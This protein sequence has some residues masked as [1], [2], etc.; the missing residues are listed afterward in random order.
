MSN[1]N[2]FREEFSLITVFKLIKYKI[3]FFI[4]FTLIFVILVII[5]S[6]IMPN[7][8]LSTASI[9]PP[10]KESGG[11]GL[12][13]FIQS[14]TGGLDIGKISTNEQSKLF[15]KIINSRTVSDYIIE[16]LN[17]S[18]HP[19]FKDFTN[20]KFFKFFSESIS[21]EVDKSGIIY[22]STKISTNF[23]PGKESINN[24]KKLSAD[25][26]NTAI[27]G[28]DKV[29]RERTVSSA[30]ISREYI[31]NQLKSYRIKLDSISNEMEIFQKKNKVFSIDEQAQALVSQAIELGSQLAKAELEYNL[32][33]LEFNNS[34]QVKF[35]KEQLDL[36]QQQYKKVQTGGLTNQDAF[37][38]PLE[39]IPVVEALDSTFLFARIS[40]ADAYVNLNK[41]NDAEIVFNSVIDIGKTDTTKY[42]FALVQAF[43][44]L[45]QMLIEQ[46]KYNDVVKLG[47]RWASVFPNEAYAY[48]FQAIGYHN[49]QNGK[50]ACQ[51]YRKVLRIDPKNTVAQKNI[52]S[53][54]DSNACGE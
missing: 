19:N 29:I 1:I 4:S 8:F 38:I 26:T 36:L 50:L 54:Q 6:F 27:K 21:T 5:Y 41:I 35:Y 22:I 42:S 15:S 14:M 16:N 24:A 32:A 51:N 39:N 48:L 34:P 13:S 44:K 31:E 23:F 46:K 47:E 25:I 11:T 43:T 20:E 33:K 7:T 2:N 30:K 45:G 37:A 9:L 3:K 12:S 17:L 18:K 10:T 52:K 49:L 40:L 53:L 28:L